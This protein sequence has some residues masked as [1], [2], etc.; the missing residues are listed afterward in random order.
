[1]LVILTDEQ[2]ISTQQVC[3]GCL[4]ANSHGLPRWHHGKLGCGHSLAKA[5]RHSSELYECQM[6][7]VLANID[8]N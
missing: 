4:L 7:F 5:D 3:S 2:I 8:G 6:G 1:M